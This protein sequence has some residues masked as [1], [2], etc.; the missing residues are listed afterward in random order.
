MRSCRMELYQ[1]AAE[2]I[3][4]T[5]TTADGIR[6]FIFRSYIQAK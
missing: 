5:C 1:T 6:S 3:N 2:D 4:E